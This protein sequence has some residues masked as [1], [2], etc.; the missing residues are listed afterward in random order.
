MTVC[1]QAFASLHGV[2]LS[3]V[4]RIAKATT[5]SATAPQDM[6]GKH[7]SRPNKI[8]PAMKKK[9]KDHIKS[10]PVMK[11]HYSRN[12]NKRRRYLSPLLSIVE[13]HRLYVQEHEGQVANP[14]VK[15]S[16]Y[17]KVFNE[18]FN[19]SFGYPKSD[20]CGACEQFRIQLNSEGSDVNTVQEKHKEHLRSAEKFYSELRL[21]TDMAKKNA[22]VVTIT[23]DFQQNLPLPH[24]PVGDL[25]YMHQLWLYIFGVHSCGDNKV[26]MFCWPETLAKRGSDEVVSCLH[27]TFAQLPPEVTALRL[28]SDGCGGQNKNNNVMRYLFSLVYIGRFRYIRHTFPVRGHSFLPNDRDFGRTEVKK[29]QNLYP[30]PVG[31]SYQTS[32]TA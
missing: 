24:L 22:H 3:R 12:K 14:R 11:S 8:T 31:R 29:Q 16:Y 9:V 30:Q 6:R 19:L 23:F 4:R 7:T 13:M 2:S 25:F 32:S 1:Q 5:T 10:F 21:D 18:E 15:Y 26:T 28:Y 17:A 20:V 27:A